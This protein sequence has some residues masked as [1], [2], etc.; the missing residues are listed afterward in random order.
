MSLCNY[1]P[2]FML[3]MQYLVLVLFLV[4][5][6][7][8]AQVTLYNFDGRGAG[9]DNRVD[10]FDTARNK[11]SATNGSLVQLPD[12]TFAW[13][14]DLWTCGWRYGQFSHGVNPHGPP[15]CGVSVYTSADLRNHNW[16]NHSPL[17]D[18][19]GRNDIQYPGGMGGNTYSQDCAGLGSGG[20]SQFCGIP[21]V[22]FNS[23]TGLYVLYLSIPSHLSNNFNYVS[24][25]TCTSPK[26]GCTQQP[27]MSFPQSTTIND[28]D[29][30][31]DT[32]GSAY[33]FHQNNDLLTHIELLDST[34]TTRVSTVASFAAVGEG[35]AVFKA[36]STYYVT[37]GSGCN[38]CNN[39]VVQQYSTATALT[40]PWATPIQIS[41]ST[42][43]AQNFDVTPIVAGGQTTYLMKATRFD[44]PVPGTAGGN[45]AHGLSDEFWYPFTFTGTAINRIVGCPG[46]P[47]ALPAS[48]VVPGVTPVPPPPFFA[49][50]SSEGSGIFGS[51][52]DLTG[53]G[54]SNPQL[55][56]MQTFIPSHSF[57]GTIEFMVAQ[58]NQQCTFSGATTPTCASPD[59]NLVV[60]L[61]NT[62]GSPPV[63]SGSPLASYVGNPSSNVNWLPG[64]PNPTNWVPTVT[65]L[66]SVALTGGVRY[67][68]VF[69][70]AS[71]TT[72]G[73]YTSTYD[74]TGT[75]PYPRGIE[76]HSSDW[77]SGNTWT[78]DAN[79]A[80]KFSA[81]VGEAPLSLGGGARGLRR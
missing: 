11:I 35:M 41:S 80:L 62:T 6:V 59:N 39:A 70:V 37:G 13:Y 67:A 17:F 54:T 52:C 55:S 43:D 19:N 48:V 24:V 57:T 9:R 25:F 31:I 22:R 33:I 34:W 28:Y 45:A 3:K 36:G 4:C 56:R 42:C 23:T 63:P 8:Q 40:G 47:G 78:T 20:A 65:H 2:R 14:G 66:N 16:V 77:P 72:V 73:S 15:W 29:P 51:H 46:D 1:C 44:G 74:Q 68:L 32:D 64:S 53:P 60:A 26:G 7:A 18:P 21:K 27:Q 71:P 76:R 38:Y 30:L 58:C 49:D 10:V 61:Y 5:G 50:Q 69:S 12:S 81:G 79:V 75:N